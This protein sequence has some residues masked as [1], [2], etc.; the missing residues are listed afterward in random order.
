[1]VVDLQLHMQSVH[2]T[3]NVVRSNC[4]QARSYLKHILS[5]NPLIESLST[6][7]FKSKAG[8]LNSAGTLKYTVV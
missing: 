7:T 1:M 6:V 3:T 4:A 8:S 2:I 5:L